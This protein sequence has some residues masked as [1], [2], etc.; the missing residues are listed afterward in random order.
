MKSP[1][2]NKAL[3]DRLGFVKTHGV[4]EYPE[5]GKLSLTGTAESMSTNEAVMAL[6]NNLSPAQVRLI[7]SVHRSGECSR[8]Q[9]ASDTGYEA[10]SGG[11]KNYL[12][13]LKTLNIFTYPAT[14]RVDLSGW[15]RELLG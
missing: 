12:S 1:I 13:S 11:F 10:T 4:I 5:T 9:L 15:A 3:D 14:G 2:P 8:E 7:E 6:R